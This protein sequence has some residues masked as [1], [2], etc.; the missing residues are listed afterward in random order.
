MPINAISVEDIGRLNVLSKRG[1]VMATGGRL[2]L[3]EISKILA[4]MAGGKD[5]ALVVNDRALP[6]QR[7]VVSA[8]ANLRRLNCHCSRRR[9]FPV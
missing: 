8:A 5:A 2:F 3:G 4:G 9:D 6:N 7:P 1:S